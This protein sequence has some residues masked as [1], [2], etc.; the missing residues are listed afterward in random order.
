[1]ED[2]RK[3]LTEEELARFLK[4]ITDPS[5]RAI[6]TIVYCRGSDLHGGTPRQHRRLRLICLFFAPGVPAPIE[7]STANSSQ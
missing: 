5:D 1:M 7:V 4:V 3:Y 6:F 2:D